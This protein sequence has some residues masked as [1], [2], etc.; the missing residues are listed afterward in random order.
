MSPSQDEANIVNQRNHLQTEVEALQREISSQKEQL[1]RVQNSERSAQR[2]LIEAEDKLTDISKKLTRTKSDLVDSNTMVTELQ[3]ELRVAE[4]QQ[5]RTS[6]SLE[7]ERFTREQAE[8]E[9]KR[10]AEQLE[11]LQLSSNS[12]HAQAQAEFSRLESSLNEVE[13]RSELDLERAEKAFKSKLEETIAS[14][15]DRITSLESTLQAE[16]SSLKNELTNQKEGE[17]DALKQELETKLRE[18]TEDFEERLEEL[19]REHRLALDEAQGREEDLETQLSQLKREVEANDDQAH[20]SVLELNEIRVS[21]SQ[22]QRDLEALQVRHDQERQQSLELQREL[23]D[24]RRLGLDAQEEFSQQLDGLNTH[25]RD[26]DQVKADLQSEIDGLKNILNQRDES[27]GDREQLLVEEAA[28]FE[29]LQGTL[30]QERNGFKEARS[31]LDTLREDHKSLQGE[32]Q[33]SLEKLNLSEATLSERDAAFALVEA[34]HE[35]QST[36]L[37]DLEDELNQRD[38]HFDSLTNDKANLEAELADLRTQ[39]STQAQE[40]KEFDDERQSLG[41]TIQTL[42][43]DLTLTQ[44]QLSSVQDEILN[45]IEQQSDLNAQLEDVNTKLT[46]ANELWDIEVSDLKTEVKQHM[47][48]IRKR[49]ESLATL[50]EDLSFESERARSLDEELKRARQRSTRDLGMEREGRERLNKQVVEL[51]A[52]V[53]Q[54]SQLSQKIGQSLDI[55]QRFLEHMHHV[56]FETPQ[57]ILMTPKIELITDEAAKADR[58]EAV[59]EEDAGDALEAMLA[60]EGTMETEVTSGSALIGYTVGLDVGYPVYLHGGLGSSFDTPGPAFGVVVNSPFGAAIGPFEIGF[61]A[62]VGMF[63]FTNE[64]NDKELSGIFAL[65]TANTALLETAQGAVS[66]QVGAGYF[67]A[68]VGFT[69]GAAF[70]YAVSGMPLVIRPYARMNATLDSGVETS[71]DDSGSYAWLNAGLILSYNISTLF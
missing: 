29:V 39:F 17:V 45:H 27:I 6:H 16:R 26:H 68:S 2:E 43:D 71:G 56:E 9:S 8:R 28:R 41:H 70:D 12:E 60:E 62:Q 47:E 32:Y 11:N 35:T 3:E 31:E 18:V 50:H 38:D 59:V 34:E 44:E 53:S 61:G 7:N 51:N 40:M 23:A 10:L 30:E 46:E 63:S 13:Q 37:Q 64:P 55:A 49:D 19:E 36:R 21:F 67:G 58:Q 20:R 65:A 14:Y 66:A 24:Q 54:F 15:E 1:D 25:I 69:A 5:R 22:N 52:Q 4:T 48:E 42:T 33:K 57:V